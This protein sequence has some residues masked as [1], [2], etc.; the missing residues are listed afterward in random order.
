MKP[1]S[2]WILYTIPISWDNHTIEEVLKG[3]LQLS[4]RMINR[5]THRKGLRLNG[6]KTWLNKK[7]REGDQLHVAVRPPEKADLVGEPVPFTTEWEDSD[8]LIVNKPAGI[9]VHPVKKGD[10]GTLAHGITYQWQQEG[11]QAKVRPVHRL[12]RNTSGLLLVAKSAYAHQLMDRE[13]REHRLKRQYLAILSGKT[14][15]NVGD[16]E[17]IRAPIARDHSHPLRRQVKSTGDEAITHYQVIAQTKDATLVQVELQ[18]GKTHQIRVHF[19]HLGHPLYGDALYNGP[20]THIRR[21]A[22]HASHLAF[23]HP[24]THQLVE[25]STPPPKDLTDLMQS[26]GLPLPIS[27]SSQS[28]P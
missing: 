4:N 26:V 23:T 19:S 3:P 5:L 8:F 25:V 13:L 28:L 20:M 6:K 15:N 9:Q 17:T 14:E 27:D 16:S 12:D 1:H 22:L 2:A 18:T 21:Q 11:F 7:L 24:L 10:K